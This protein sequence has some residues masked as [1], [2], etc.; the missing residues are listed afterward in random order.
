MINEFEGDAVLAVFGAPLPM[1]DHA[2]RAI[3][4]AHGMLAAVDDLNVEWDADGTSET[5]RAVGIDRLAIRIGLHSGPVVAGNIGS[6]A[7][8]KYAVIGDTVNTAS[9]VEG[10]NKTLET[11]VLLTGATRALATTKH[12]TFEDLGEHHVKGRTEPVHVFTTKA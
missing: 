12:V 1:E 7:R 5:W 8:I 11:S 3:D 9:R 2:N 10:L 4:A 6:Q